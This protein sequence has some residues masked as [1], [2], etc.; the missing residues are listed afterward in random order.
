MHEEMKNAYHFSVGKPQR[1]RELGRPRTRWE[2]NIKVDLKE[3]GC[4]SGLD[5]S[6]FRIGSCDGVLLTR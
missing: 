4:G 1:K 6:D 3:T 5:T 2:H